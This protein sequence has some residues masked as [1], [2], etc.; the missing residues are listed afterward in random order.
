MTKADFVKRVA[1]AADLTNDQA[2]R[3]VQAVL[4]E[5]EMALKAGDEV[6]FSGFGKFSVSERAA[7]TGVNPRTG[8]KMKIAAARVPRFTAGSKLK[9]LVNTKKK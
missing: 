6:Q 4:D 5:L 1:R 3:A 9:D 2:T 7:R 8:E